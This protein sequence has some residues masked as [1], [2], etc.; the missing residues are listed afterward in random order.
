VGEAQLGLPAANVLF[1]V[2]ICWLFGIGHRMMDFLAHWQRLV[3]CQPHF[4][5]GHLDNPVPP[6]F[7]PR[8]SL[9]AARRKCF[10]GYEH[11]RAMNETKDPWETY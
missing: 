9:S 11:A 1:G 8:P 7:Q 3:P 2:M 5:H 6:C 4:L 10:G